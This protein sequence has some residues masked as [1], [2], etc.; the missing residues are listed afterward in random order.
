MFYLEGKL[1]SAENEQRVINYKKTN[2]IYK[3]WLKKQ[4]DALDKLKNAIKP[5]AMYEMEQAYQ[6]LITD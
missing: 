4:Q 5:R 3:A 1:L 2:K 6:K